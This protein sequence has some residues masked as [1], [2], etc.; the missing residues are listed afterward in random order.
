MNIDLFMNDCIILDF[1]NAIKKAM[2]YLTIKHTAIAYL[3]GKEYINEQLYP[4][5]RKQYFEK[6]CL[7]NDIKYTILEE[8]FSIE[9]VLI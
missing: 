6:Y 7:E 4:D 5:P 1:K 8:Q 2:D 9:L 3:G